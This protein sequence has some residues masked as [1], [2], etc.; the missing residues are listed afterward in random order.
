M[1]TQTIRYQ[2]RKTYGSWRYA[3]LALVVAIAIAIAMAMASG[4]QTTGGPSGGS[5]VAPQTAPQPTLHVA[6]G[7]AAGHPLP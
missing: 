3:V 1:S 7:P 6:S 4:G 2:E 5:Q